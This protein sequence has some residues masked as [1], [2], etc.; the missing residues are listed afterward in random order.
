MKYV[1]A[2]AVAGVHKCGM[3]APSVYTVYTVKNEDFGKRTGSILEV[4]IFF[5]FGTPFYPLEDNLLEPN[6]VG[7]KYSHKTGLCEY[8]IK[9][10]ARTS[11]GG[12]TVLVL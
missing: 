7:K 3:A 10:V 2:N 4:F 6:P 11:T 8:S 5:G 12:S 9:K 1:C